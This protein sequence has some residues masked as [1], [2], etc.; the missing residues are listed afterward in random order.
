MLS[1]LA[2][3][4]REHGVSRRRPRRLNRVQ[5][6]LLPGRDWVAAPQMGYI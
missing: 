5:E 1:L 4:A 3:A 6:R 2:E